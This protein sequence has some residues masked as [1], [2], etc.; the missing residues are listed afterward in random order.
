M[1]LDLVRKP[2]SCVNAI[3]LDADTRY[4]LIK[5]TA[6]SKLPNLIEPGY[7]STD[8]MRVRHKYDTLKWSYFCCAGN[9]VIVK[10]LDARPNQMITLR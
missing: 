5:I 1:V 2:S 7:R 3:L 10:V 6:D 4:R 9:E 8:Q